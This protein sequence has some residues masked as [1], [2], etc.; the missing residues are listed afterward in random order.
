MNEE[1]YLTP[2]EALEFFPHIKNEK[3]GL[4]RVRQWARDGK[5]PGTKVI[6]YHED[7]RTWRYLIP[8]SSLEK[9]VEDI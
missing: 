1:E 9:L 6:K 8:K 5:L 4:F 3:A 7:P 2:R